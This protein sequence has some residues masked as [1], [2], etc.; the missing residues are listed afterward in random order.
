MRSVK[1]QEEKKKKKKKEEVFLYQC[2][3]SFTISQGQ[4][5]LN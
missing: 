1:L 2:T 5:L 4:T 3:K